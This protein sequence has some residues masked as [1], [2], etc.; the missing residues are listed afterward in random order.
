MVLFE[1]H[2]NVVLFII[3]EKLGI[4]NLS[5]VYQE[6]IY[7]SLLRQILQSNGVHLGAVTWK[8]KAVKSR[9]M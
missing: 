5:V 3:K 2:D 7:Y 9:A 8:T 6:N 1:T 4:I